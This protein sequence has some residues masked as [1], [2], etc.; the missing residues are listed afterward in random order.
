MRIFS[1]L[2]LVFPT[3]CFAQLAPMR[4][5]RDN[6]LSGTKAIR[7]V[8]LG[9][10]LFYEKRLSGDNTLSCAS[11]HDPDHGFTDNRRTAVGINGTVGLR[12]APTICNTG[13]LDLLFWDGR[14]LLLEGQALQPIQDAGEMGSN[15]AQV[16]AEL[17][18]IPYYRKEFTEI[19]GDGVTSTNLAKALAAFERTIVS[20]DSP[21]DR[22]LEGETW[23][24]DPQQRR[25]ALVFVGLQNAV[26]QDGS[27]LVQQDSDTIQAAVA[28]A[29]EG[30]RGCAACH[31]GQDF[32][33]GQFHNT[34]SSVGE[35]DQ[36]RFTITQNINDFK[37]FKTPTL[38]E[39][40]KTAPYFHSGG[41]ATLM[42]VVDFYNRGGGND[43]RKDRRIVPLGLNQR[44]KDDLVKFLGTALEGGVYPQITAP[45]L[46]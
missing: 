4:T 1:L 27:Y 41:A 44:Q 25:G 2:L 38:R 14:A 33:D 5:P 7:A 20:Y 17:N 19:F 8:A 18:A 36:G 30:S 34:G 11:C 15:L 10:Q 32:R 46:P 12:N 43:Q 26:M 42:D 21:F 39:L 16:V 22:F 40:G 45:A 24:L 35:S 3:V 23:A 37:K 6:Q 13:Y 28:S 29:F 31:N 9:R